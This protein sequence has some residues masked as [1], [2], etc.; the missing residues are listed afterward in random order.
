M[1]DVAL[2]VL[3]IFALIMIGWLLVRTGYLREALGEE[4][5]AM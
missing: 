3:P 4:W 1:S 2:N 5:A